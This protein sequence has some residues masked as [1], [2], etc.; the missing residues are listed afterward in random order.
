MYTDVNTSVRSPA[1]TSKPVPVKVGVQQG[2][3]LSPLIFITVMDYLTKNI[4][5]AV[6][7]CL[8][9]ADDIVLVAESPENLQET[10]NKWCHALE[11]NGL[12]ISRA[13]SE[14]MKF[15]FRRTCVS[16]LHIGDSPV[17]EV[18]KFK[19]LGSILHETAKCDADVLHRVNAGWM[20]WRSLSGVLCD[21]RMPIRTKGKVYKTCVRPVLLYG[22]ECWTT[23]CAHEANIHATEMK[24]LRWAGGVTRL[25]RI[26][27]EHVRGSFKVTP[28]PD[29]LHESQLRWYG[30]VMRREK[31][32]PV[33]I[34]LEIDIGKQPPG[35]PKATWWRNSR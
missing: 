8:L 33:K 29:K 28:I 13:K 22:A 11:S 30:H 32:H 25:D 4:Q 31:D 23:T 5:D 15:M 35:R 16:S 10:L 18:T 14:F 3:A 7:W 27:N 6:P 12:K 2:S 17:A 20:K 21:R 1:G 24:M 19:Y 26:R 34:A 9:Y